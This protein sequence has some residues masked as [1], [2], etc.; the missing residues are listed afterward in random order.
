MLLACSWLLH[1]QLW[2]QPSAACSSPAVLPGAG[3]EWPTAQPVACVW[4]A[5][6]RRTRTVAAGPVLCT[7]LDPERGRQLRAL[8]SVHASGQT[9]TVI[10]AGWPRGPGPP[11]VIRLQL[12]CMCSCLI[13][14]RCQAQSSFAV[15][16]AL[17]GVL[18]PN[19]DS[20]NRAQRS[21]PAHTD[22]TLGLLMNVNAPIISQK[23]QG[24]ARLPR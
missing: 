6:A 11:H 19:L 17:L 23:E 7:Q 4:A 13:R 2:P 10:Y 8:C 22:V 12:S 16:A 20:C 24:H 21:P 5:T 15:H 18:T 9:L 1:R 14:N 3:G